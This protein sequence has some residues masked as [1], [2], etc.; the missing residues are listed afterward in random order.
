MAMKRPVWIP[1]HASGL[2]QFPPQSN[3]VCNVIAGGA[4]ADVH[5]QHS[6]KRTGARLKYLHGAP[7]QMGVFGHEQ[8][9]ASHEGGTTDQ[10]AMTL[11]IASQVSAGQALAEQRGLPKGKAETFSRD[12]VHSS[13]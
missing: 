9:Q 12:G 4:F 13:G 5:G 7:P 1:W 10:P 3:S 8:H 11:L 6:G 2:Q